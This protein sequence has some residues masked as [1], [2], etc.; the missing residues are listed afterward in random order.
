[1][2]TKLIMT[3]AIAF[4]SSSLYQVFAQEEKLKHN[5]SKEASKKTSQVRIGVSYVNDY[6]YAGR[7]DSLT[8]P[9]L[10][11]YVSYYHRSGFFCKGA[12][13]YLTG[14][15]ENRIDL[16][17]L[18]IGYGFYSAGLFGG[19]STNLLAFNKESYAIQSEVSA[20]ANGY[21]GYDVGLFDLTADVSTLMGK[22]LDIISGLELNKIIHIY[23][24]RFTLNPTFYAIGGTQQYYGE[25]Y[26]YRSSSAK[27]R[28]GRRPGGINN[29]NT[30]PIIVVNETSSFK[31]LAFEMSLPIH[32]TANKLKFSFIP[33]Y[34]IPVNPS[35]I[36]VNEITTSEEIKNRLYFTAEISVQL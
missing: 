10:T 21:L 16:V 34:A 27:A 18:M 30:E 17:N 8:S 15:S 31:I 29:G 13:S 9:Y 2:K 6:V 19:A 3:V 32:Y 23:K 1:M 22:E 11:P 33:Q 28:F 5:I 26:T 36:T 35:T 25:Y 4:L 12:I 20:S 14:K 24:N 7:T